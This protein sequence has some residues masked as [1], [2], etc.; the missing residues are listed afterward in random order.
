MT[1]FVC[2]LGFEGI[3]Q[4]DTQGGISF[5]RGVGGVPRLEPHFRLAPMSV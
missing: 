3:G 4:E 2:S 1:G 5:E